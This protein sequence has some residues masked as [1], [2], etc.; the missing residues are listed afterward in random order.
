[1]FTIIGRVKTVDTS[2]NESGWTPSSGL[3]QSSETELIDSAH[4]RSLTAAK[5]TS[6]T[7]S[8][9]EIILKQQGNQTNIAAPANM[10]IIRSSDY[11]GSY[12]SQTNTWTQG[13]TGWV[14]AGNGYAE[15]G[16]ASVRGTVKAGSIYIN[17][18]NRWKTDESGT[19]IQTPIFKVGDA[20]NYAL[21][22]GAGNFVVK[23]RL[24][25]ISGEIA[26]WTLSSNKLTAGNF[27]GNMQ[28]GGGLGP[29]PPRKN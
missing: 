8:A 10:A 20:N 11:N 15:F 27:S 21:Y 18:N 29:V 2:G 13:T 16:S 24:E 26:G 12:S 19:E 25:S 14:I 22:D 6:G 28:I 9:H 5:I 3:K 17:A 4:I 1:M 7:I 23:G